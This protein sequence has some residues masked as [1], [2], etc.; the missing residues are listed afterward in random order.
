MVATRG[1]PFYYCRNT[2]CTER[3]Y[4]NAASLDAVVLNILY[5][6]DETG[7]GLIDELAEAYDY[8]TWRETTPGE[9][10]RVEEA[11]YA[12]KSAEAD[13]DAF[14]ADTELI[15]ILGRKKYND[16]VVS[17]VAAVNAAREQ[18]E[19]AREAGNGVASL[20]RFWLDWNFQ[21]RH[22]WLDRMIEHCVVRRGREPLSERTEVIISV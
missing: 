21:E 22:E 14:L 9:L 20:G 19:R 8:L 11:E 1:T 12:L 7:P 18:L 16:S 3:T 17:Y 13:L 4:A 6:T 15:T 10:S 5:G 2:H